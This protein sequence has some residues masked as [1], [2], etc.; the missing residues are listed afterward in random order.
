M[1]TS[2]RIREVRDQ[3]GYTQEFMAESLGISQNAYFKIENHKVKVKAEM[4]KKIA[5]I[6]E[7]DMNNLLIDDNTDGYKIKQ[8]NPLN[9]VGSVGNDVIYNQNNFEKERGVWQALEKS[10][11]DVIAS[12]EALISLLQEKINFLENQSH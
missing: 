12:K 3:K 10:L 9:S 2:L 11:N 8:H 4:L 1:N 7:T 6:L 5:T